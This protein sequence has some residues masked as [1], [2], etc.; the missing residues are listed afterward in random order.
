MLGTVTW[1]LSFPFDS[2]GKNLKDLIWLYSMRLSSFFH[3]M[4]SLNQS[5]L[6]LFITDSF[7]CFYCQHIYGLPL[8]EYL[9]ENIGS[10]FLQFRF[11]IGVFQKLLRICEIKHIKFQF[12]KNGWINPF[13]SYK[14][15][16]IIKIL[17][18]KKRP[19][20]YFDLNKIF[21]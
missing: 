5:S 4:P 17:K 9:L 2:E 15:V 20:N 6:K 8:I 18:E 7:Q 12:W 1:S 10:K 19:F 11:N 3:L 14:L 13:G 21:W 16:N